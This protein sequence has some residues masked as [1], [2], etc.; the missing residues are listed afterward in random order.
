MQNEQSYDNNSIANRTIY[1]PQ[2]MYIFQST[3]RYSMQR[4]AGTLGNIF[5][6][7]YYNVEATI[8]K[9]EI[10]IWLILKWKLYKKVQRAGLIL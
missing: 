5:Q 1:Q 9:R 2:N 10:N 3:K 4:L 6:Y 7:F 8:S